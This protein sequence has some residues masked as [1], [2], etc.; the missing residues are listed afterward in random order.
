MK[1]KNGNKRYF[2]DSVFRVGQDPHGSFLSCGLKNLRAALV[3]LLCLSFLLVF[4]GE[5]HSY[6]SYVNTN[7]NTFFHDA[8]DMPTGYPGQEMEVKVRVGYNGV[9]G[10]ANPNSDEIKNV[11][12][13]LS[14]DQSYLTTNNSPVKTNKDN[15]YKNAGDGDEQGEAQK[16]AWDEGYKAGKNNAYKNGL[17]Y[18]YPV[19]GGVY[20]FE[21]NASL[22]TQE[23]TLS[24]LKK[25]EYKELNFK[26]NV[27]ADALKMKDSAGNTSDGYFGVPFTIWYTDSNGK[28]QNRTEFVNVFI[29]ES[30]EVKS[31][32]TKIVE[33]S[34]V[35][36]ENQLTPSGNYPSV[37]NYSVNFRNQSK[38]ILYDVK[39]KL[40]TSLAEK[41]AVQLTANAKAEAQK[42]F[43]FA[44]NESNYDREYAV[45]KPGET[46]SPSYSMAIKSNT[47]SG[48][49]PLSYTVSYKVA[50]GGNV[51]TTDD[52]SF[53]VN[54]RNSTMIQEEAKD[55]AGDFNANDRTKARLIVSKYRTEPEQV[56]AGKDFKLILTMKNASTSIAASNILFTLTS[57]KSQDAAVFSIADGSN[58]FVVNSLAAGAET[59]ISM[60]V[61]AGAG[62]DPKSYVMTVNEKYDS[63]EFKNAEE[64]VDIDIPVNQTARMGFSNF[65]VTPESVAVGSESDA[66]FGINN[67]GKVILYNVTAVFESD[68][69]KKATAY[70]GNIKPGE[71]GNV[72]VM[73]SAVKETGED[74]TIPVE[75]QY[76]DVNGNKFTEKTEINL[77]VTAEAPDN[78]LD[79]GEAAE[80]NPKE[81]K[82]TSSLLFAVPAVLVLGAVLFVVKKRKGKKK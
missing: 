22:F 6:A 61:R 77:T 28:E 46:V 75:I 8:Q 39:I 43:P 2:M 76:E 44:I 19:D 53:Y 23:K 62:V 20:P 17:N 81:K 82:K 29:T 79:T 51:S 21:V 80:P 49:Y 54:V 10:L 69:I 1:R 74:T 30:G 56:Y 14:N 48:Y 24:S 55:K 78:G 42:D 34:F 4:A 37:M 25:G 59:E 60:T 66:M 72:D 12:V 38:N 3:L 7:L 63:P 58:T 35:V 27:R 41:E 5:K 16:D 13:R 18:V 64:K 47:A 67:T 40:N 32:G 68:Y 33:K 65:S 52:Y 26:V 31:S 71:T 57:E 45:V 70:V 36:G 11:R 50:P 73:L 9:N 15:P